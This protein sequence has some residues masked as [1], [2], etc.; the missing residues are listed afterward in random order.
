MKKKHCIGGIIIIIAFLLIF[1]KS[2]TNRISDDT[3]DK[4]RSIH[5]SSQK[6]T[7]TP[8][9]IEDKISKIVKKDNV[10]LQIYGKVIDQ[11]HKPVDNAT[12]NYSIRKIVSSLGHFDLKITKHST[13]SDQDG[14]FHISDPACELIEIN[15][16]TK[17]S[18][19]RTS[20]T[21]ASVKNSDEN[22]PF[23]FDSNQ[24]VLH[25]LI[26]DS[27]PSIKNEPINRYYR[28]KWNQGATRI[29]LGKDVGSIY[30]IANRTRLDDSVDNFAWSIDIAMNGLD[31]LLRDKSD[32]PIAPSENYKK[33]YHFGFSPN[34]KDWD[35]GIDKAF[36]FITKTGMHAL[37]NVSIAANSDENS[38]NNCIISLKVN[39]EGGRI[40][41]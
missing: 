14:C 32:F 38:T 19:R 6:Q 31:M 15:E 41:E 33:S 16:I 17:D 9:T 34:D 26:S 35:S 22:K 21:Y 23:M 36:Y 24:P 20:N 1:Y 8:A 39:R 5:V 3:L 4:K 18:Y 27:I 11:D 12:V 40:F 28:V 29:P 2:N 25:M 10:Y 30:I 13:L 37:I 7:R